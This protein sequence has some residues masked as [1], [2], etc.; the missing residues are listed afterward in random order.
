MLQ[1]KVSHDWQQLLSALQGCADAP[2]ATAWIHTTKAYLDEGVEGENQR[3]DRHSLVIVTASHTATDVA[4]HHANER[5]SSKAGASVP[6]LAHEAVCGKRTECTE[7]R[8][9]E[10]TDL[11]KQAAAAAG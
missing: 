3:K 2:D 5:S 1:S 8:R 9:S 11:R 4:G 6:A 10:H 7:Q